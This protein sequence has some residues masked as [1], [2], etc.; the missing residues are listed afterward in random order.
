M[1]L[2]TDFI[3]VCQDLERQLKYLVYQCSD[4]RTAASTELNPLLP[5]VLCK[6]HFTKFPILK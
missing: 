5:S 6:E 3:K 4:M 2:T 1:T